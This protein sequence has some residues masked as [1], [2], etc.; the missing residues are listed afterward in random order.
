MRAQP[1]RWALG[2]LVL[3][4]DRDRWDQLV[5]PVRRDRKAAREY[6]ARQAQLDRVVRLVRPDRQEQPVP[7]LPVRLARLD[8]L[9]L[10]LPAL[11]VR[12]RELE[13]PDQQ[14]QLG[15]VRPG[16]LGYRVDRGR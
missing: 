4:V 13:R 16:L 15:P 7:G 2:R 8:R 10:A 3:L 1:D 14:D 6:R 11:P 12:H 9:A 5:S